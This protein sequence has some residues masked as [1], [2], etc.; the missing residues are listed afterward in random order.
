MHFN[1]V[2][3]IYVQH[4]SSSNW[5]YSKLPS[6][7]LGFIT[8]FL[9]AIFAAT[10]HVNDSAK[11]LPNPSILCFN[12]SQKGASHQIDNSAHLLN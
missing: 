12:N 1:E 2:N 4:K 6:L 10:C 11:N 3:V 7:V 9:V 8:L 5:P